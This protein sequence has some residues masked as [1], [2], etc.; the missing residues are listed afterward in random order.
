MRI[1]LL[2]LLLLPLVA[3]AAPL[4]CRVTAITD[5][6]TLA[7]FDQERRK[8]EKIRLRGI[9]APEKKQPFGQSSKQNLSDLVY[10]K[11]VTVKW[12]KRDRW[13]R[14]IGTVWAAPADCPSCG[15]T[16]DAGRAQLASGMAW[17]FRRYANEQPR[18]ERGAYEFEEGEAK[19]RRTG[20]WRDPEPVAPWA[21][22]KKPPPTARQ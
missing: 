9:D 17:W 16:L 15:H 22:R 8:V 10:G 20:L 5:G 1:P 7:C 14:I 11:L 21:W 6:D 13:G 3:N 4:Q 2:C 19:A 18:E 12:D